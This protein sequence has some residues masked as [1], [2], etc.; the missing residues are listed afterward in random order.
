MGL[1]YNIEEKGARL[2]IQH[3][4]NILAPRDTKRNIYKDHLVDP[5][6]LENVTIVK[7]DNGIGSAL[8]RMVLFKE[9]LLKLE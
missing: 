7:C 1:I 8:I 3:Q 2:N 4:Q 6:H 9:Q 5:E